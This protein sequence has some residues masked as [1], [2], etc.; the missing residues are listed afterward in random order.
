MTQ[1]AELSSR[2][3][4]DDRPAA[5]AGKVRSRRF[6]SSRVRLSDVA[7]AAGVSAITVSRVVNATGRV[8]AGTR[9]S[10]QA[11]IRRLGYA[12]HAAARN[13]AIARRD[14][15]AVLHDGS[16]SA[17]LS[18]LLIG[19]LE[20]SNRS[21]AQ[22]L[23][24]ELEPWDPSAW[25]TLSRLVDER[26]LGVILPPPLGDTVWLVD[27][28]HAAQIPT[29]A[30]SA[31]GGSADTMHVGIDERRAAYELTQHLL[32]LGHRRIGFIRGPAGWSAGGERWNGFAAALSAG[33]V[34]TGRIQVAQG[35]CT[36]RSGIEAARMLLQNQ[37]APTAI[38][39][40]C[41][42]MAAA[43]IA[44]ADRQGLQVPDALTVVGFDDD[45]AA[46]AIWPE[47]TTVR[48]PVSEMAVEAVNLL[49]SAI[50]SG[51]S[52]R[53]TH[54]CKKV[55]AHHLIVRGSTSPP[56]APTPSRETHEK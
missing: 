21:D 4:E 41:D 28:L 47:L 23:V 19:V 14:R 11:A 38:F 50:R 37:P 53:R 32:E 20:E 27:A 5:A 31:G 48:Q 10:V 2:T 36:F 3:I 52:V 24:R 40:S 42:K 35:E 12:P 6:Q 7:L 17:G 44:V 25:R 8:S 51:T 26:V 34:D 33:G 29:V 43:V 18:K 15:I 56:A 55:V 46:C 30:V 16:R 39:A 22:L 54:C 1:R 49:I 9:K 45:L 13:L